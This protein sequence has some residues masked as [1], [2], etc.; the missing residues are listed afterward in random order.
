MTASS[1]RIESPAVALRPPSQDM[2]LLR[3]GSCF[4]TRL[5]FMRVMVRELKAIYLMRTAAVH[6]IDKFGTADT[7]S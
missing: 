4:A 7:A 5:S 2:R 6:G 3:M 1:L